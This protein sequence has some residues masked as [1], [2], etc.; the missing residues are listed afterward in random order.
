VS[1]QVEKQL[2]K[3]PGIVAYSLAVDF[4]RRHFWTY[5]V[6]SD[7]AAVPAFTKSAPH[8]V[9]VERFRDWAGEGAAFVEWESVEPKL[10]WEEAFERLKTPSFHYVRP[11]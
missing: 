3:S 5:T 1:T 2:K 11:A 4:L 10:N 6:W 8:S 9:A 7:Q